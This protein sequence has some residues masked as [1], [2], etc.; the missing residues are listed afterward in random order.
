[1][2]ELQ[3]RQVRNER[4]Q[5]TRHLRSCAWEQKIGGKSIQYEKR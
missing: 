2:N 3:K 5:Q 1:M 4:G